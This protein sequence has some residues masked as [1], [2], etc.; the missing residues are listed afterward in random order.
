MPDLILIEVTGSRR[1]KDV[2]LIG[3][4]LYEVIEQG[5]YH[6]GAT[7]IHIRHGACPAGADQITH[8]FCE[9]EAEWFERIGQSLIEDPMPADWDHCAED[10]PP[11]PHRVVKREGDI[12]HP[13]LLPDYCPKAGPRRNVAMQIKAPRPN[14]CL[15]FPLPG[16][17]GTE[18]CIKAARAHDIPVRRCPE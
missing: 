12:F 10:C 13:G 17:Y 2:D 4:T 16:S 3:R 7:E 5:V 1:H 6:T 14:I 11:R 8:D 18:N 9:S 15:A